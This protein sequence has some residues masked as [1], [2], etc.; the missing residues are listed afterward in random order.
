MAVRTQAKT[1]PPPINGVKMT[2]AESIAKLDILLADLSDIA[3]PDGGR[4]K[5]PAVLGDFQAVPGHNGLYMRRMKLRQQLRAMELYAAMGE[6]VS[7]VEFGR[8][9]VELASLLIFR[10]NLSDD[11][12]EARADITAF[13]RGA[14]PEVLGQMT[15]DEILDT[16]ES[17]DDLQESVLTPMGFNPAGEGRGEEETRTGSA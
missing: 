7:A 6:N 2:K 17:I 14:K 4:Y 12:E 10:L 16:F 11:P 3:A 9:A 8:I 5:L 13:L 1:A 15:P